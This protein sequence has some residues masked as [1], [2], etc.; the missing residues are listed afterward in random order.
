VATLT[1]YFD[2]SGAPDQGTVLVVGGFLSFEARWLEFERRWNEV[3]RLARLS[4]F[5]MTEFIICKNE[6]RSWKNKEKKR[7]RLLNDLIQI[8][9]DTVVCNFGSIVVLD[10]WEKTNREYELAESDFQT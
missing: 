9:R 3:L 5:H 2:A 1:G 8:I 4:C 6:F 10:D 7:R